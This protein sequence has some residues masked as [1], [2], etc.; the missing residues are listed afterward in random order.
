MD[1][2]WLR[3]VRPDGSNS[4]WH[5]LTDR[6]RGPLYQGQPASEFVLAACG[7]AYDSPVEV[8]PG[9]QPDLWNAGVLAPPTSKPFH[10]NTQL[11]QTCRQM[12]WR[13][14]HSQPH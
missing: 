8:S 1:F 6:R 2:F 10:L 3:T 7:E 11:C 9:V 4:R 5:L 14:A 13:L 12:A